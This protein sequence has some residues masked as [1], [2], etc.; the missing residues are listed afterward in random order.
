MCVVGEDNLPVSEEKELNLDS[1]SVSVI[2]SVEYIEN[3]SK[4]R[5]KHPISVLIIVSE[6]LSVFYIFFC[7]MLILL[8][9]MFCVIVLVYVNIPKY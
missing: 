1:I 3:V 6:N 2:F 7:L 4:N 8:K 9:F 5:S